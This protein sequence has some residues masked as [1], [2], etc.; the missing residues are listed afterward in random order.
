VHCALLALQCVRE[1]KYNVENINKVK[2][3]VE[4]KG[5]LF[6]RECW[7]GSEDNERGK[8]TNNLKTAVVIKRIK[9]T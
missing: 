2:N 5:T 7:V 9:N 1:M 8:N 3:T 4:I 6:G